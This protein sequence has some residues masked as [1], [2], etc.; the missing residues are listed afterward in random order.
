MAPGHVT[1]GMLSFG[2]IGAARVAFWPHNDNVSKESTPGSVSENT[3]AGPP[4]HC[5]NHL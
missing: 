2:A 4:A 5:E 3:M 1:M